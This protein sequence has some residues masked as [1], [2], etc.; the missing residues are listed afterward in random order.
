DDGATRVV[1]SARDLALE[2]FL[3]RATERPEA[4]RPGSL[5]PGVFAPD[6]LERLRAF[7]LD[8]RQLERLAHDVGQLVDRELDLAQVLARRVPRAAGVAARARLAVP[9]DRRADVARPLPDAARVPRAVPEARDVDPG[10]GDR[11]E[12]L[13]ATADEFA[14][15]EMLLQIFLDPPADNVLEAATVAFDALDHNCVPANSPA[16]G[17]TIGPPRSVWRP[18]RDRASW[19][20][21]P[22]RPGRGEGVRSGAA[23][24]AARSRSEL[25]PARRRSAGE[26]SM[27]IWATAARRAAGRRRQPPTIPPTQ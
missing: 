2:R 6:R 24:S 20:L 21:P 9:A 19:A 3:V 12:L 23:R 4:R 16:R 5:D 13:A 22:P 27:S 15:R 26:P 18:G 8:P 14:A 11:D 25:V 7:R 17:R 10:D 1:R